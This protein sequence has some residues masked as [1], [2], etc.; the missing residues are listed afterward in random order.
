MNSRQIISLVIVLMCGVMFY[1]IPLQ[2]E[3]GEAAALTGAS[4]MPNLAIGLIFGFSLFDLALSFFRKPK[5]ATAKGEIPSDM[6]IMGKDQF[7]G[8]L[9]VVCALTVFAL[10][11]RPIGYVP[12]S[13]LLLSALMFFTGG[14]RLVT[15]AI[16]ATATTSVL[17]LGLRFGFGIHINAFPDLF[18]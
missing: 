5:P 12:A 13:V 4:L 7:L 11:L 6:V 2:T 14:K 3:D 15:I 16:I 17:Y 9:M 8:V 18:S 1:I 10:V